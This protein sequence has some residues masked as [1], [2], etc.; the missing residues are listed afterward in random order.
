MTIIKT[1]D[2]DRAARHLPVEI[3]QLCAIQFHRFNQNQS[4]PRLHIKIDQI[5]SVIN[6][7][8]RRILKYRTALEV[9]MAAGI[10]QKTS[11]RI[12]G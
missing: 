5:V 3:I 12:E 11:V 1:D 7:K 10:I 2:F 8:P 4:D 9:A 6:R